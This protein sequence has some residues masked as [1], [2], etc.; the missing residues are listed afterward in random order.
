MPLSRYSK[1]GVITFPISTGYSLHLCLLGHP[2]A[3]LLFPQAS[4]KIPPNPQ[5]HRKF[6]LLQRARPEPQ[7]GGRSSNPWFPA[8]FI[9]SL[10]IICVHIFRPL[11]TRHPP[12][13]T[14]ATAPRHLTLFL[15][16]GH[17]RILRVAEGASGL[18]ALPLTAS[19][20]FVNVSRRR[21]LAFSFL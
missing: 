15:A 20:G 12:L 18:Q 2:S 21:E 17:S 11:E 4:V 6:R 19:S 8:T 3:T 1:S 13:S 16:P 10:M 9:L 14:A 7:L 5:G